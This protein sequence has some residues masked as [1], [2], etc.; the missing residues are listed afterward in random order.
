MLQWGFVLLFHLSACIRTLGKI[1]EEWNSSVEIGVAIT[2]GCIKTHGP[3]EAW[4]PRP[5]HQEKWE[6][7]NSFSN[8]SA[9]V[10]NTVHPLPFPSAFFFYF[11]HVFLSF[12]DNEKRNTN[13][14]FITIKNVQEKKRFQ[15]TSEN[16]KQSQTYI[17]MLCFFHKQRTNR[18]GGG[19][20][21]MWICLYTF[22]LPR[23]LL[24]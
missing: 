14:L 17:S 5:A 15:L 12:N 19:G 20:G 7:Q 13:R 9:K 24:N 22:S 8:V 16:S 10:P 4:T 2:A 3:P 11:L 23:P 21:N 18:G 6:S 1:K